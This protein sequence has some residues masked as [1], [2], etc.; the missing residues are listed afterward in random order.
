MKH[1]LY[2]VLGLGLIL[3]S[4]EKFLEE[5]PTGSLTD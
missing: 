2:I 4:C 5:I 3:G 1:I